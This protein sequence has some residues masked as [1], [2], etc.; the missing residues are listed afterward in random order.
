M[1]E[2]APPPDRW[3]IEVDVAIVGGGACGLVAGLR[4]VAAGADVIVLERDA[5]S[6]G[7]TALSS[8]F[9]PAAG[10]R[11]Q[12]EIHVHDTPES[13][14]ADIQGKAKG[15]A[16]PD[17]ARTVS[18]AIAPAIEWLSDNHG[19]EW[20]VLDDFLYPGHSVHRMHAVPERTGAG[21]MARLQA[22]AEAAGVPVA[23]SSRATTLHVAGEH[24]AGLTIT[25]PDGVSESIGCRSLIL[26]CNGYGGNAEL[27]GRHIPEIAD[28]PYFG[29]PGNTGDA[30]LWGDALGA[31]VKHLSGYQGHGSLAH[32]HGILI[33]WALIMEGGIQVNAEGL[34]FSN[35]H[36]G[37]SEQ[38]VKVLS[39]PDGIAWNIYDRRL[40]EL[41]LG[42]PDYTDA[43][44][45]GAVLSGDAGSLADRI[46]VPA[47]ALAQTLE[48]VRENAEAGD[49]DPFGRKF[50]SDSRLGD[51]L[52]AIRVTGALFHTQG[53]LVV[54]DMARVIRTDGSAIPGLY[55]GGGAACGVSG[56]RVDGY[57]SGNGLLT[58][59]ALGYVA[60]DAA[61][62]FAQNSDL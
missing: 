34:R 1:A 5:S 52:F 14:A 21:L 20:I 37:Y 55:A 9:I 16:N 45:A 38:A 24:L 51:E 3:D 26:A 10:T 59:I 42:F 44:A 62:R 39:Q 30:I 13:L 33:T 19:L 18:D 58:A 60:G 61:A 2:I 23:H 15:D 50:D 31:K 57:L 56:P 4:A 49:R 41:G 11:F 32:P 40:H 22:A 27:V 43:V 17:I 36:E 47:D 48:S 12:R 54:D 29:H 46:G 6:T 25:R 53:G 7:S 8:G 28:A 35:E